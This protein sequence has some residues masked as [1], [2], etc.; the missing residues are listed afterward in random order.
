MNNKINLSFEFRTTGTA[1][2]FR[3]DRLCGWNMGVA[4]DLLCYIK[5]IKQQPIKCLYRLRALNFISIGWRRYSTVIY[6]Q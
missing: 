4:A 6:F 3:D 5:G 2:S 1:C